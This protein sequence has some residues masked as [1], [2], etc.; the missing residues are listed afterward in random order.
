[1]NAR[2]R[3]ILGVSLMSALLVLYFAFAG[4]KALALLGTGDAIAVLMG[5]ALL[6]FPILG[7]WALVREIMF[8]FAS[9]KLVDA[10]AEAGELPEELVDVEVTRAEVRQVADAAFPKYREAAEAP[11]AGWPEF[12]RLGLV[13]D[14]AGD[15]KRARSAI[16]QAISLKRG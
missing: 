5:V 12:L 10:L 1:M 4:L 15:R 16:R 13:Y 6:V 9:T 8:G 11:G 3:A 14:A 2:T 7:A